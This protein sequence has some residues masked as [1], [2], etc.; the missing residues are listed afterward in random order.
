MWSEIA[1][2]TSIR[3]CAASV[4]AVAF[5]PS[6]VQAQLSNKSISKDTLITAIKLNHKN[7]QGISSI[8]V[9]VK[10][11]YKQIQGIRNFIFDD[12]VIETWRK[13]DMLKTHLVGNLLNGK[14]MDR[15]YAWDGKVSTGLE[16][17]SVGEGD[18]YVNKIKENNMFY[19]NFYVDLLSYPDASGMVPIIGKKKGPGTTEW[20]P[21]ALV[22]AKDLD[23]TTETLDDGTLCMVAGR[24]LLDKYWFEI[25][26]GYALRKKEAYH[27]G[28]GS[29]IRSTLL[30]DHHKIDGI[31]LPWKLVQYEYDRSFKSEGDG[32]KPLNSMEVT[33]LKMSTETLASA[34]FR[35]PAPLGVVV[36]DNIR[37]VFF[38]Q[39]RTGINPIVSSAELLKLRAG[40]TTPYWVYVLSCIF[41]TVLIAY[42]LHLK[43]VTARI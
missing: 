7:Y 26:K 1:K 19:Y 32:K 35:I 42:L 15:T 31:W 11:T 5:A 12:A 4:L 13:S 37:G 30:T 27:P 20:L 38:T 21:D 40:R 33:V 22:D 39:Y 6:D 29:L 10:L 16:V 34:T 36:H 17:K 41:L 8:Y 14:V 18:Y 3:I 25:S 23:L 9:Y 24:P 2:A 28:T 43:H